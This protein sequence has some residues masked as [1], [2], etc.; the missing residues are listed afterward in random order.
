MKIEYKLSEKDFLEAQR[1]R[2]GLAIR[3]LPF[4]GALLIL[5]GVVPWIGGAGRFGSALGALLIGGFLIFGQR[6]LWSYAYRQYKR[7][8]CQFAATF[9]DQGLE[10]SSSTTG[11]A[12]YSWTG[13]TRFMETRNLFLLFQGPACVH[14]FPKTCLRAGEIEALREL[15]HKQ[16]GGGA[17]MERKG[18]SP[19]KWEVLVVVAAAFV[20]MLITIRN[21]LRQSAPNKPAQTQSTN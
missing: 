3:V 13:F 20:L 1:A 10:V 16:V 4:F 11:S 7:L 18:R 15:V 8:H 14:I 17:E 2:G 19:M 12:I 6:L 21:V 9:S 5:A